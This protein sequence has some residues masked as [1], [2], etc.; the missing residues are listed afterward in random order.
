MKKNLLFI[1]VF[2]LIGCAFFLYKKRGQSVRL[3]LFNGCYVSP[4]LTNIR[5]YPDLF[6]NGGAIK[7]VSS[8]MLTPP[9][10]YGVRN[11]HK[12]SHKYF[13]LNSSNDEV[14]FFRTEGE[15]N[16]ELLKKG[17]EPLTMANELSY[18]DVKSG[19]KRLP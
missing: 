8:F 9:L 11:T 18:E 1:G 4:S 5:G 2:L 14:A 13:L 19:R 17:A 12:D 15:L 16:A 7:E 10:V 3:D 6:Y